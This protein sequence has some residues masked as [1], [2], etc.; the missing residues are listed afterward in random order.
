MEKKICLDQIKITIFRVELK[1]PKRRKNVSNRKSDARKNFVLNYR[2]KEKRRYRDD[3][4][5]Q[6]PEHFAAGRDVYEM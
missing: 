5:Q 2:S 1:L 3:H 4:G 6:R